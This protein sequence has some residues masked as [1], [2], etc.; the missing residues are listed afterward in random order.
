MKALVTL[1]LA[2]AATSI[3]SK[4]IQQVSAVDCIRVEDSFRDNRH[5][6]YS[7]G[8]NR[9]G[10]SIWTV[11]CEGPKF[12]ITIENIKEYR[13]RTG[14]SKEHWLD[15]PAAKARMEKAKEEYIRKSTQ[16][17]LLRYQNNLVDTQPK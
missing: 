5:Y 6:D 9:R 14:F 12:T 8:A 1:V 10:E 17:L 16:L 4:E 13:E 15:S 3:Q 2:F 11:N 7:L